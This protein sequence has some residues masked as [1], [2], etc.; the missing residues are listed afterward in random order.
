MVRGR[1]LVKHWFRIVFKEGGEIIVLLPKE[2]AVLTAK[3]SSFPFSFSTGGP[4]LALSHLTTDER[5]E[6][7]AT[8]YGGVA[9]LMWLFIPLESIVYHE[10]VEEGGWE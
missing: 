8:G 10:W 4:S 1:L 9:P 7:I 6:L 3:A 2:G 5:V